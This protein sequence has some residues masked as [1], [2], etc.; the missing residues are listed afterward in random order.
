MPTRPLDHA[1]LTVV[2]RSFV[3]SSPIPGSSSPAMRSARVPIITRI[4]AHGPTLPQEAVADGVK[5][6]KG[7]AWA[8]ALEGA[9]AL[10]IYAGWHLWRM[11]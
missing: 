6:G 3:S 4:V 7:L 5:L 10:I 2:T 11:L 9:A 8:L 1:Q